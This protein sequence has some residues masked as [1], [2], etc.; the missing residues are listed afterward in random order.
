MEQAK[1]IV[2]NIV[3][4]A[5]SSDDAEYT[6][7]PNGKHVMSLIEIKVID[8]KKFQSEETDKAYRLVFRA[9]DYDNAFV[10]FDCFPK[11]NK[12]ANYYK[13]IKRM[14][15]SK[16]ESPDLITEQQA[17]EWMISFLGKWFTVRTIQNPWKDGVWINVDDQYIEPI[18]GSSKWPN[19]IDHFKAIDEKNGKTTKTAETPKQLEQEVYQR[20]TSK[21][22]TDGA[23]A[24]F[25][26]DDIP[27]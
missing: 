4:K 22:V 12:K 21:M 7:L 18:E 6:K 9:K 19:G 23:P 25:N 1:K 8:K 27:F 13:I 5:T 2:E 17:Y 24:S 14:S 10:T 15:D 3:K 11:I 20:P 26:D 16:C